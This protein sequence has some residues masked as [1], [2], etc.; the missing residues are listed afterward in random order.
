M[1]TMDRP[2]HLMYIEDDDNHA[3]IVEEAA[4]ESLLIDSIIR[5]RD[6]ESALEYFERHTLYDNEERMPDVI[7]L[8]LRLP[9]MSGYDFLRTIKTDPVFCKIPVVVLSAT[10]DDR[11]IA[12]AY[13]HG[14]AGY[15][16]KPNDYTQLLIKLAEFS[17]YWTLTSEVPVCT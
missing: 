11:T 14:A 1:T 2:V 8:D 17:S 13:K 7:L 5:F 12:E 15:I 3:R 6:A 10:H 4:G 9:R 16:T